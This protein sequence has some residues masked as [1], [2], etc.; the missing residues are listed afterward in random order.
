MLD[1]DIP[2]Q[3]LV[4]APPPAPKE[5]EDEGTKKEEA[6]EAGS[7]GEKSEDGENADDGKDAPGKSRNA[8]KRERQK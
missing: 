4:K 7:K 5:G 6:G 3:F 8:L 1:E 2:E